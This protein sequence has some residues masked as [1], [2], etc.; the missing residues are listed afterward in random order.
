MQGIARSVFCSWEHFCKPIIE[1]SKYFSTLFMLEEV[2]LFTYN[3]TKR[4]KQTNKL[5]I[6]TLVRSRR[7]VW[8]K[9]VRPIKTG[10]PFQL[11]IVI[12]YRPSVTRISPT[13]YVSFS[14]FALPWT[15][16][17]SWISTCTGQSRADRSL[18]GPT[19]Q[20]VL[21]SPGS[22]HHLRFPAVRVA[23]P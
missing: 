11:Q 18:L 15:H 8:V 16:I 5:F 17:S 14:A 23:T 6:F 10:P 9:I 12:M 1:G 20:G 13:R 19:F 21:I 4:K 3:G 22:K 2:S 7:L